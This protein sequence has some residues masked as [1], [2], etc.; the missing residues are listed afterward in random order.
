MTDTLKA[1]IAFLNT[2]ADVVALVGA[3]IYGDEV[4]QA[5]LQRQEPRKFVVIE[6]AGG[7]DQTYYKRITRPRFDVWAF[8]ETY[9]EAGRVERAVFEAL[10]LLDRVTISNTLLH[11]VTLSGGPMIDRHPAT[12]WPAKWR[13]V[14]VF[15]D[16][17]VVS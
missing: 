9:Y 10:K 16:E 11:G 5:E 7:I 13:A 15:A 3:R 17:R 1:I 14:V 6:S 4:P 12:S 2:S 8:G